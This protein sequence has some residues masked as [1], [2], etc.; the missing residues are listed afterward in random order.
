MKDRKKSATN[1]ELVQ[2]VSKRLKNTSVLLKTEKL[3]VKQL[4]AENARL[5]AR[6]EEL[7]KMK[8]TCPLAV[9]DKPYYQCQS[10]NVVTEKEEEIRQLK[11]RVEEL[12]E[13]IETFD[14]KDNLD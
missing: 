2:Y 4:K 11:D 13:E 9:M 6:V 5:K 8:P 12:E 1:I 3:K 14:Y 10:R 7:E